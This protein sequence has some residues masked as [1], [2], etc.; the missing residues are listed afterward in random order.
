MYHKPIPPP[1]AQK[2][3]RQPKNKTQNKTNK[4]KQ[5]VE[6]GTQNIVTNVSCISLY[7]AQNGNIL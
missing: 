2:K 7:N 1:K 3:E 5:T 4:N 6:V